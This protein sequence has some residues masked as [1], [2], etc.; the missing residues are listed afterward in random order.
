MSMNCSHFGKRSYAKKNSVWF[1]TENIP[2]QIKHINTVIMHD[3]TTT[4]ILSR[5][6]KWDFWGAGML[7]FG[8][9]SLVLYSAWEISS[10]HEPTL[11]AIY[12]S[13]LYLNQKLKLRAATVVQCVKPPQPETP[14]SHMGTDFRHSSFNFLLAFT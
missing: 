4:G 11:Y 9:W 10:R 5:K 3:V 14:A 2:N 13:L 7:S 12:F 6:N 1:Y 8:V